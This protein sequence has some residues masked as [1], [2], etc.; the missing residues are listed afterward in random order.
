MEVSEIFSKYQRKRVKFE[1]VMK[2]NFINIFVILI[3]QC[4]SQKTDALSD[5]LSYYLQLVGCYY[6]P[7]HFQVGFF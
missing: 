1:T 4:Y 6:S 3:A 2:P 5:E 7:V